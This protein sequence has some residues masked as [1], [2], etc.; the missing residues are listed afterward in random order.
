[1]GNSCFKQADEDA[2]QAGGKTR[3]LKRPRWRS[4][5]PLTAQE[6][7]VMREEFWVRTINIYSKL[8]LLLGTCVCVGYLLCAREE[9]KTC[10]TNSPFSASQDTEPHYGGNKG[11]EL[12]FLF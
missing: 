9:K 10:P 8:S 5:D 2:E 3:P 6:L 1:M 12:Y 4:D 11:R 7:K